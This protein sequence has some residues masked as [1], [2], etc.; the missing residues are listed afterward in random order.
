MEINMEKEEI[1]SS[2]SEEYESNFVEISEETKNDAEAPLPKKSKEKYMTTYNKF[3]EWMKTK[4]IELISENIMLEY[5]Y[6]LGKELKPS[7]LWAMYSMLKNTINSHHNINIGVYTKLLSYL[8]VRSIGF[9]SQ[10]SQVLKSEQIKKFLAEAPDEIYLAMKV[11]LI[12]G[13][14]GACKRDELCYLTVDNIED[15]DSVLLVRIPSR[16]N[17]RRRSFFVEKKCYE[18]VKKYMSLRPKDVKTPR[19]FLKYSNGRCYQQVIG[20]N[21]FS[22]MPKKIAKFLKLPNPEAFTGHCFKHSRVVLDDDEDDDE[23][24][25][26][27]VVTQDYGR[28]RPR[29]SSTEDSPSNKKSAYRPIMNCISDGSSCNLDVDPLAMNFEH[30]GTLNSLHLEESTNSINLEES[31]S[32]INLEDGTNSINVEKTSNS[33]NLEGNILRTKNG[34]L[35]FNNCSNISIIINNKKDD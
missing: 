34:T 27:M 20:V 19:F 14:S 29:K 33:F 7:T 28:K 3:I 30:S 35:I 10:K 16:R 17:N 15:K 32:S 25:D 18:I 23:D 11:A 5:F 26:F 24:S 2:D 22:T 6:Q 4:Q 12:F 9:S 8:K 21:T 1:E 31:T 13:V